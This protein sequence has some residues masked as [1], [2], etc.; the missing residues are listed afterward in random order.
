MERKKTERKK[1]VPVKRRFGIAV[2]ATLFN[3]YQGRERELWMVIRGKEA[4]I[5]SLL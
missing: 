3:I 5:L 2:L 1:V 4:A